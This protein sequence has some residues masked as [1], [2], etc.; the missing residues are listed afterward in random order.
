MEEKISNEE[1]LKLGKN[2]PIDLT[3]EGIE[4]MHETARGIAKSIYPNNEILILINSEAWRAED[5]KNIIKK[6]LKESGIKVSR[7]KTL[8]DLRPFDRFNMDFVRREIIEYPEGADV[9][10]RNRYSLDKDFQA[11][12]K[13]F[14]TSSEVRKRIGRICKWVKN[15]AK[16]SE[17]KGKKIHIIGITHFEII[18]PIMEDLFDFR[19]VNGEEIKRAELLRIEFKYD[20]TINQLSIIAFFRGIKKE[21]IVFDEKTKRFKVL[22]SN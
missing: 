2:R 20:W 1:K 8:R 12:N 18:N 3:P 6:V 13:N 21:G 16:S 7:Q 5:S 4:S 22:T 9:V 17:Y 15:L 10:R 19:L 14:E 11:P